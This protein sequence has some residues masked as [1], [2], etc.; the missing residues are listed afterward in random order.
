MQA[1][2]AV[3]AIHCKVVKVIAIVDRNEGERTFE[4]IQFYWAD[5]S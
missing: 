1:I 2:K 3:E 5:D 4:G